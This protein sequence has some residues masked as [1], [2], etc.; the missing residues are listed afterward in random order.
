[1]NADHEWLNCSVG[2]DFL[3][4]RMTRALS[5]V[6]AERRR[7]IDQEGYTP[8]NDDRHAHGEIAQAAAD[9]LSAEQILTAKN[10]W[11][12][13]KAR[14]PRR[15]QL[16]I[17]AALALAEIERLDRLIPV[18]KPEDRVADTPAIQGE[19]I[20]DLV[21]AELHM[22]RA[23]HD[24]E[25]CRRVA[26]DQQIAVLIQKIILAVKTDSL[27]KNL[28]QLEAWLLQKEAPNA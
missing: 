5:A 28:A 9:Y 1:M 10:S 7:Q 6:L 18:M 15:R 20:P 26:L 25:L 27:P 22:L 17:G 21:R 3:S 12:L 2:Q 4:V 8:Q 11:A 24:Q 19:A 16:V 23:S 14:H 13:H